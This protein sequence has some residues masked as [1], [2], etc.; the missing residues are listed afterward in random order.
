MDDT[1]WHC[2]KT[3]GSVSL[4]FHSVVRK[5]YTELSIFHIPTKFRFIWLLGFKGEDFFR[6]RPIRNKN[7]VWRSC[8]L[9]DE[10]NILYRGTSIDA[11]YQVSIHLAKR[12]KRRRLFRNR[13]I[14]NKNCL[15]RTGS[16]TDRDERGLP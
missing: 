12:F 16:L 2:T 13:S 6:N 10:M 4:T 3:R 14:R 5:L 11:S 8:L 9:T 15:W 1:K 7:C